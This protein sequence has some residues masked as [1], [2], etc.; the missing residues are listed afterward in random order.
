MRAVERPVLMTPSPPEEESESSPEM[1]GPS[2]R[3]AVAE[4]SSGHYMMSQLDDA[5][6]ER[7]MGRPTSASFG[8]GAASRCSS[9]AL[10]CVSTSGTLSPS[11][12]SALITPDERCRAVDIDDTLTCL[13]DCMTLAYSGKITSPKWNQFRGLKL[14]KKDK[15]RLNNIIWREY[16]MQCKF[17]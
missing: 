3:P 6:E 1:G 4:V 5:E 13:L 7:L 17:M 11:Q 9:R 12:S 10:S 16:H 14:V 8:S 2:E 15:V